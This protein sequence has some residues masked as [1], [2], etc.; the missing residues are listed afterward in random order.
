M[1]H[2][3]Q[4]CF[5][6][7][8][9]QYI[10]VNNVCMRHRGGGHRNEVSVGGLRN[11][12]SRRCSINPTHNCF[13]TWC[14]VLLHKGAKPRV[15]QMSGERHADELPFKHIREARFTWKM[16]PTQHSEALSAN[17]SN[18][19]SSLGKFVF[20]STVQRS[21]STS[22]LNKSKRNSFVFSYLWCDHFSVDCLCVSKCG[23]VTP[24]C[25]CL[26]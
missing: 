4:I 6:G 10:S 13:P 14:V 16:R 8:L 18:P 17:V 1:G 25:N 21:H 19:L 20:L 9:S 2:K 12:L 3:A 5:D 24:I 11:D 7:S 15:L 26:L 23:E 22:S